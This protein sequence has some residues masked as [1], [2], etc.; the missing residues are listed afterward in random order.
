MLQNASTTLGYGVIFE[1]VPF[2]FNIE[3]E[4]FTTLICTTLFET[5]FRGIYDVKATDMGVNQIRFKSEIDFDG[6]EVTRSYLD[7]I[8]IEALLKVK[9]VFFYFVLFLQS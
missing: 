7:R 4:V 8:D 9:L 5:H 2:S 3:A 6:A 1:F